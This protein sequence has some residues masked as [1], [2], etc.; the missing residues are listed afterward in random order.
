MIKVAIVDDVSSVC[1][2]IEMYLSK[3]SGKYN[4][5]I[6]VEPYE[7]G[8][9]FCKALDCG[10]RYDLIFLD[11][12]FKGMSGLDVCNYIR[13][14][15]DD[16]LQQIVFISAKDNYSLALHSFHPLDF[17]IKG[18][19]EQDIEKVLLRF[20]K[21]NGAWNDLF[22]YKTGHDII[23]IKIK[24]IKYLSVA[25]RTVYIVTKDNKNIEY[26]GSLAAAY[27]EQLKKFDFLFLHKQY[28]VNPIYIEIYEYDRVI[29]NDGKVIPIGSSRRKEIRKWQARQSEM[30]N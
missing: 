8:E 25:N 28:V 5:K 2:Q 11:I 1:G 9:Q 13:R 6:D 15:M 14:D 29:L 20:L 12:E 7:S 24:D 17:L 16:E 22:E 4:I 26:Y 21:I 19:S 27:K 18:I 30:R 23:K 10:E 3:L